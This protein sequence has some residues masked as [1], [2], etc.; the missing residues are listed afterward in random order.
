VDKVHL[1]VLQHGLW[2]NKNHLNYIAKQLQETYK[3]KI[4]TVRI[5]FIFF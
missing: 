3:E 4:H 1:F 5:Y 2:G